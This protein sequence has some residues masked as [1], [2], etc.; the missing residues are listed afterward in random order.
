MSGHGADDGPMTLLISV[1][2]LQRLA[3]PQSVIGDAKAWT[4]NIGVVGSTATPVDDVRQFVD[5]L[6]ANP[7]LVAGEMGGSLADVRQKLRTERHVV[8]GTTEQQRSIAAALGWEFKDVES[9]AEAAGWDFA[10][11]GDSED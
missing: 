4:E 8:I 6:G 11:D 1:S 5:D 7:D 3:E 10:D 9:A 2:A